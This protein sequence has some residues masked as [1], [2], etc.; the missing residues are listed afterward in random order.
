[1]PAT[2]VITHARLAATPN[3]GSSEIGGTDWNS[4]HQVQGL[5]QIDNTSDINKPV[6][7]A[8]AAA[9]AA[10]VAA[11]AFPAVKASAQLPAAWSFSSN[12]T[13]FSVPAGGS[14]ADFATG[15]GLIVVRE[16][17]LDG[18]VAVYLCGGGATILMMQTTLVWGTTGAAGTTTPA[19][20]KCSVAYSGT[21]Y[22]IYNG[23]GS[24]SRAM[25][26]VGLA[27]TTAFN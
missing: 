8:Q 12:A 17:T 7:T 4:Q 1:M 14:S 9:I 10:A 15:C 19:A 25:L 23:S 5:D 3:D 6:S 11:G 27:A 24:G 20:G 16:S 18:G 13:A 22:R 21:G 2:I 26:L